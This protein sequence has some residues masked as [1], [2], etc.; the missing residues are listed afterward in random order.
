MR[1][2]YINADIY[3]SN[4]TK[5]SVQDGR[6]EAFYEGLPD[7]DFDEVIDLN[8][9]T[10]VPGFNDAHGHFLGLM[11][12]AR[13]I[14]LDA[15]TTLAEVKEL[16][17][18]EKTLIRASLFNENT[19]ETGAL[20][21]R[22]TLDELRSDIPVLVLRVCG[23]VL[24]ANSKAIEMVQG[25]L[26]LKPSDK[27]DLDR[28]IFY[29]EMISEVM[30]VFLDPSQEEI[31]ADL[32]ESEK[33][34]FKHGITSF[35]TDDF[36]TYPVPYERII[37][38]YEALQDT[39][40]IRI[41]QQCHLKT[42][43]L[44]DDFLAK[45]YPHQRYGRTVMGPSKLLVDGSLGGQ[46]AAMHAPYAGSENTGLLN[47]SKETLKAYIERLNAVDMDLS[48][49]AIGDRASAVILDAIEESAPRPGHRHALIHAQLT[50]KEEVTRMQNLNVGAMIQPIFLDD[51]IPLLKRLLGPKAKDTYLFRQLFDTVPTALSTDAPIVPISPLQNIYHAV[52]RKSLKHPTWDAH[53]PEEGLTI[54]QAIRGYTEVGAYFMRDDELGA[55]KPGFKADFTVIKDIDLNDINSFLTAQVAMT[56]VEGER[57]YTA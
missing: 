22:K 12:I 16:F 46:T 54:A 18:D 53:L 25:A 26:G 10:V 52:T 43:E 55:L 7:G 13:Q 51:D 14:A 49:H 35:Q 38:A 11:Y 37:R 45:G 20:L 17:R 3:Q 19:F 28:G 21:D 31:E 57:V 48:W 42:L 41:Q 47:Y 15:V 23:H 34:A 27:A 1:T 9:G 32:L 5:F 36:I 24:M 33:I 29:E 30:S 56:V 8:D 44:M 6:F 4:A 2:L 50:G 39:L 40:K